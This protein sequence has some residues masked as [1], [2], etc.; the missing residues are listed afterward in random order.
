MRSSSDLELLFDNLAIGYVTDPFCSDG[1]W[2]GVFHWLDQTD[3]VPELA[4]AIDYIDF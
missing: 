4:S 2:H 1:T 3:P